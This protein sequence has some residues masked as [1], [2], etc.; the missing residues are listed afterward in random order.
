MSKENK[1]LAES[2][3]KKHAISEAV[4]TDDKTKTVKYQILAIGIDF[5]LVSGNN[6]K[7]C[8]EQIIELVAKELDDGNIAIS[9]T[10]VDDNL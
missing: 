1:K 10:W 7:E 8:E 4:K 9:D 3:V 2:I 6:L 5:T